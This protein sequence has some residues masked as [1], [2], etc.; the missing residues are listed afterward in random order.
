MALHA[1]DQGIYKID[2][3][4]NQW[5]LRP[6]PAAGDTFILVRMHLD[7]PVRFTD[8]HRVTALVLHHDSFQ[9]RLTA[10]S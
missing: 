9:Y 5:Q 2:H 6:M 1:E 8:S 7:L 10:D 4:P 3:T